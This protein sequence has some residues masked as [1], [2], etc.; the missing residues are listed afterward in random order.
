MCVFK[1]IVN[2]YVFLSVCV[3]N[4]ME[5]HEWQHNLKPKVAAAHGGCEW[6]VGSG[7]VVVNLTYSK[8]AMRFA[9][10]YYDWFM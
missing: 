9:T 10:G 2:M 8:E 4:K 3:T 7:F 1:L 5:N 6:V